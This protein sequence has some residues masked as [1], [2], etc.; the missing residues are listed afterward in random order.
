MDQ[1]WRRRFIV[2]ALS[3]VMAGTALSGVVTAQDEELKPSDVEGKVA[4]LLP[5]NTVPRW[6]SQDAPFFEEWMATLAPNVEVIVSV[7]DNDPQ[8]QLSQARAAIAQ[9]AGALVVVAVDGVQAAKI[10]EAADEADVPVIAYTRQIQDAPVDYM[11]G[12]DPFEIGQALG[13]WMLENTE[14]GDTI[15]VIAG[16]V[17]DSFAHIERDGFMSVLQPAFDAGERIMVGDVWTPGWDPVNAHGLM[18]AILTSTQNEVD[19][20]LTANDSTAEGA[21]ASLKTAGLAG[22]IPVTGIDATLSADKRI[23]LGEQSMSVWR[24]VND[25]AK[26]AAQITVDLLEGEEP[27]AD[28]FETTVNNGY[29]DI[30]LKQIHS[31]VIDASNMD[32][33]LEDGAISKDELCTDEIPAGT[34]P[35]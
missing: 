27:P 28:F 14:V 1:L 24:S 33:L 7:A 8:Q 20:V 30:P 3:A 19:A 11:V 32:L 10:V 35:C 17:T 6:M 13:T 9:G 29:A 16:S 15:A 12:D 4:F 22:K 25:L 5:E 18:D 21:I 26:Y 23:L 31:R 2:G 34:G